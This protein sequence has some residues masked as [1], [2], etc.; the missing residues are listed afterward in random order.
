MEPLR[1]WI[2]DIDGSR[3]SAR[4][5]HGLG[6]DGRQDCSEIERGVH[7]LRHFAKRPQF[8]HRLRK[9]TTARFQL[10]RALFNLLFEA[11]IGF[12]QLPR[13]GVELVGERFELVAGLDGDALAE[14]AAAE[15]CGTCPQRLDRADHAAG[16]KHPGEHGNEK[17]S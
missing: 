16:E 12:L 8:P 4:Q 13:H 15:P 1:D 2:D 9:L 14:V 10:V 17:R 3:L 5:V 6:D 11:R 7:C